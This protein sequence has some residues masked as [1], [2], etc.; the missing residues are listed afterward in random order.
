MHTRPPSTS[1]DITKVCELA[2]Q[3]LRYEIKDY[4]CDLHII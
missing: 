4:V 3:Q 2:P 1:E